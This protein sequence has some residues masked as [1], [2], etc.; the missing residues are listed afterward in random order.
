MSKY[1]FIV[2]I[3]AKKTFNLIKGKQTADLVHEES[4][5]IEEG[6][7]IG[8]LVFEKY[9]FRSQNR[10]ALIVIIDNFKGVTSVRS[11]STGSS[12]GL[13]LNFDWGAADDFASSVKEILKDYLVR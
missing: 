10:A 12:Q 13:F 6:K 7:F 3:S 8:T 1:N 9:Y 11:I 5:D 2:D 4:F